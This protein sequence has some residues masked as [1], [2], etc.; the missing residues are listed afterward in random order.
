MSNTAA[1]MFNEVHK[2][3]GDYGIE[4]AF[5]NSYKV[6][7]FPC[8][9]RRAK[10]EGQVEDYIPFDPEARLNTESNNRKHS[11][12]NGYTQTYIDRITK[13][14]FVISIA[15]YLFIIDGFT[16]NKISNDSAAINYIGNTINSLLSTNTGEIYANIRLEDT[17]LFSS[18][19]HGL[20]YT[21]EILRSQSASDLNNCAMDILVS[22]DTTDIF[23]I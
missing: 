5:L 1:E 15:G 4:L 12:L 21:T 19:D 11:S 17:A 13:N 16:S 3:N 22:T 20:S 9:R 14:E 10:V 23:F 6:R 7:A 18:T 8:G 2:V